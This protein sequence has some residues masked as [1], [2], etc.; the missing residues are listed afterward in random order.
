MENVIYDENNANINLLQDKQ[1]Y[2]DW[3]QPY[4]GEI[5]GAIHLWLL[6]VYMCCAN[7]YDCISVPKMYT[8]SSH[9]SP[10]T[11]Y[12]E[13]SYIYIYI[14]MRKNTSLKFNIYEIVTN[15]GNLLSTPGVKALKSLFCA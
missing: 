5:H 14:G 6:S 7:Q 4:D 12:V 9:F 15:K 1:L 2:A 13:Y 8:I 10:A 3:F 11:L